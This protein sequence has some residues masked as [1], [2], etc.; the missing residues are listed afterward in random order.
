MKID[1]QYHP[2][3]Q[4]ELELK[5]FY[6]PSPNSFYSVALI[7]AISDI[8]GYQLLQECAAY[9][10]NF[11]LPIRFIVFGYTKDD[12]LLE[13]YSNINIVGNFKNFN[14]LREN[15]NKNPCDI[16]AFLSIWPETYSYTLSEAL[17]LGLIPLGLNIGAIGE[18]IKEIPGGVVL[19]PHAT[20]KKIVL[21]YQGT[22]LLSR[23]ILIFKCS[24]SE[25]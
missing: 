13:E 16:A 1:V 3:F 2:E 14:D 22:S 21:D 15:L 20:A 23:S 18:R 6:T 4:T 9:A 12:F 5:S 10:M 25:K 11:M 8:K 17:S 19:E 24:T 7:G